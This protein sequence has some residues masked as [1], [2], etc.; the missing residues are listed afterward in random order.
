MTIYQ[1][2]Y[3]QNLLFESFSSK[4]TITA[5]TK[6][7]NDTITRGTTIPTAIATPLSDEELSCTA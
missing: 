3:L 2:S 6:T 4:N 1:L 7:A 5:T